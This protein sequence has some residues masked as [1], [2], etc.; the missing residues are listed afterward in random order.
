LASK[1]GH[2]VAVNLTVY[3][4]RLDRQARG[5]AEVPPELLEAARLARE[6]MQAVIE[7]VKGLE[8]QSSPLVT[9]RVTQAREY[10]ERQLAELLMNEILALRCAAKHADAN[11]LVDNYGSAIAIPLRDT[12]LG[13]VRGRYAPAEFVAVRAEQ[14]TLYEYGAPLKAERILLQAVNNKDPLG[15]FAAVYRSK[16]TGRM[17]ETR[18]EPAN[19]VT[20]YPAAR[21]DRK[22]DAKA[23]RKL[24]LR[25]S[26]Y[27][28]DSSVYKQEQEST[29]SRWC[30]TVQNDRDQFPSGSRV[31]LDFENRV[32]EV[33]E[34]AYE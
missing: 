16:E 17:L 30:F 9:H 6:T 14:I 10:A 12:D 5:K 7:E 23:V 19:A 22:L 21:I 13:I 32:V 4:F 31:I 25:A 18:P 15:T 29:K 27:A 33:H 3:C 34:I 20:H 28:E 2:S 26:R 11:R 1:L 8:A 24:V